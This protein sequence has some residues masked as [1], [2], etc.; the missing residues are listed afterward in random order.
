MLGDNTNERTAEPSELRTYPAK[1]DGITADR[2]KGPVWIGSK[3]HPEYK[4]KD[5]ELAVYH[6]AI[7]ISSRGPDGKPVAREF[8]AGVYGTVLASRPGFVA[9]QLA[10]GN[11]VQ[12]LHASDVRLKPGQDVKPDTIL[13]ETGHLGAS[14]KPLDMP[15]HLH[16]QVTNP[17]G[18]LVDPDR[19]VLAGRAEKQDRT[20]KWPEL[21]WVDVGPMLIDSV[22]PKVGADGVVRADAA[23]KKLYYDEGAPKSAIAGTKWVSNHNK[24]RNDV[25]FDA[26]GTCDGYSNDNPYK[27]K[28]REDQGVIY[29][30]LKYT[31][32]KSR[33]PDWKQKAKIEGSVLKVWVYVPETGKEYSSVDYNLLSK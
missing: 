20:I 15:I 1:A 10:D 3:A 23:N 21:K 19:A 4:L 11:V 14:G 12:Y 13:G 22:K 7:D 28:W 8:T 25:R 5:N 18:K 27:G 32:G 2:S 33:N 16:I 6:G 30:E 26:D 31:D 9:V 17:E 29:L 24:W